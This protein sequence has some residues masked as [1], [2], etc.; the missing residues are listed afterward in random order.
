MIWLGQA[1]RRKLDGFHA[2]CIRKIV[3][4]PPSYYSRVSNADV[5][6][7]VGAPKLSTI[8]LERQLGYFG[9]LARR[10]H[11][12]PVRKMVFKEDLSMQ[13]LDVKRRPGRPKF[14][15]TK[16]VFRLISCM[17]ASENEFRDCIVVPLEWRKRVRAF[18]KAK[19][20]S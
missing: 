20:Q 19:T 13:S 14:E 18:C 5:L 7:E 16:E 15:W 2:R 8:L 12:C 4:I 3:K 17:F 9:D 1:A 10:P 6:A 11:S